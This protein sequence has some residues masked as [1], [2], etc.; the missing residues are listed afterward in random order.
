MKWPFTTVDA[1]SDNQGENYTRPLTDSHPTRLLTTRL[2]IVLAMGWTASLLA[3]AIR[4]IIRRSHVGWLLP[5]SILFHGW[6]LIAFNVL[7]YGEICWIAFWC[8]RRTL[9]RERLF[10]GGMFAD[11]VLWPAK[12]LLPQWSFAIRHVGAFGLAVATLA[13]LTLLMDSSNQADSNRANAAV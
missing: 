5:Q 11:I 2:R 13:A 4:G 3:L 1:L 12:M 6:V 8:I 10:M 9:G 7:I